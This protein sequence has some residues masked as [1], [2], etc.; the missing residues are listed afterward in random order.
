[1]ISRWTKAQMIIS[2]SSAFSHHGDDRDGNTTSCTETS[3]SRDRLSH[4]PQFVFVKLLQKIQMTF[5]FAAFLCS[6]Y[7]SVCS[8]LRSVLLQP[9]SWFTALT[10]FPEEHSAEYQ[11]CFWRF[12]SDYS[13]Q[14]SVNRP[15]TGSCGFLLLA[16]LRPVWLLSDQSA[17]ILCI[18]QVHTHLSCVSCFWE[19][20]PADV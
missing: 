10:K 20:R 12:P 15:H 19:H 7:R 11:M 3:S 17:C 4:S 5:C 13:Q 2:C 18:N 9:L 14:H 8:G 6:C 16:G 1:M